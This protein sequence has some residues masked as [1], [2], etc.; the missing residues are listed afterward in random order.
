[1]LRDKTFEKCIYPL[2]F[3]VNS[4]DIQYI[5][6][7]TINS[8]EYNLFVSESEFK[9]YRMLLNCSEYKIFKITL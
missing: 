6:F 5:E 8:L 9:E 2:V 7:I 4:K 3:G 1:M